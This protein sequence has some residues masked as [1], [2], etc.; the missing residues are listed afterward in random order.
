MCEGKA[1]A[2]DGGEKQQAEEYEREG[3]RVQGCSCGDSFLDAEGQS[4]L[5]P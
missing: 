4:G 5:G 2:L 1:K 3:H